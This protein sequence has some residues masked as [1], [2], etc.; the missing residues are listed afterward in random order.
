MAYELDK[1]IY[2]SL[3][4]NLDVAIA[5]FKAAKEAHKKTVGKSAPTAH[6][7]VEFLVNVYD[8]A[9]VVS[10]PPPPPPPVDPGPM[11]LRVSAVSALLVLD[12]A[13]LYN[14]V[15][16][17]LTNHPVPSVR[18]WYERTSTWEEDHPVILAFGS[19]FGLTEEQVHNL[20]LQAQA[21]DIEMLR[22]L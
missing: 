21:L 17:T 9:Y 16:N 6:P 4:F 10:E 15:H 1:E 22:S 19:E 14:T 20:F 8:G 18:I 2:D 5:D 12:R 13:G 11:P 7:L 3:G